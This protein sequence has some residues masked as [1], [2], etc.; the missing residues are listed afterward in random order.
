MK[1]RNIIVTVVLLSL[2]VITN[3]QPL[4]PALPSGNPVPAESLL[5]LLPVALMALG[6]FSLKCKKK[7]GK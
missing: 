4:P 2:A 3:A 5:A 6:V 1:T 7:M